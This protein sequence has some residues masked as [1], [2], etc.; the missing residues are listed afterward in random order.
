MSF[1][2]KVVLLGNKKYLVV[3]TRKIGK[4]VYGYLVNKKDE[5]DAMFVQLLE[6]GI[7]EIDPPFLLNVVIPAFAEEQ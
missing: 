3:D 7:L 6:H 1:L 4:G 5:T 2:D